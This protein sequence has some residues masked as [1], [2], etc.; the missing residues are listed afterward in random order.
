MK[1]TPYGLTRKT[2]I[3]AALISATLGAVTAAAGPE[4]YG[5]NQDNAPGWSL[6]TP[7]ERS[8]HQNKMWA[9]K[10]YDECKTVQAEHHKVMEARAKAKGV[11]LPAPRNDAC[12]QMKARGLV[13]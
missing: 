2:L 7:A 9:A 10:T 12:E 1:S 8:E 3:L 6:M 11:T 5:F 4:R 13:K